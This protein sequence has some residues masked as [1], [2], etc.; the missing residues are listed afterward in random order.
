MADRPSCP[1]PATPARRDGGL[2]PPGRRA[3]RPGVPPGPGDPARPGRGAGR[4]PRRLRPGLAQVGDAARPLA[5]RALVRPDPRQHLPQPAARRAAAGDG[6]LRRGR[7][8]DRRPRRP[9]RGPRGRRRSHRRPV[10]GPPGRRGAALLPRPDRRGHRGAARHP[11]GDGPVA[12]S[13]TRSSGCTRRST[14]PTA[15]GPTDDRP[16]AGAAPAGVVRRCHRRGRDGAGR[17]AQ[18]V[19]AIPRGTGPAAPARRAAEAHAPRR[20]G[21]LLVGGALAAG[22]GHARLA[23]VGAAEPARGRAG[24]GRAP[25]TPPVTPS[26][27]P[28]I[29]AATSSRSSRR[30]KQTKC[31]L[32]RTSCPT[33]RSGSSRQWRRRARGVSGRHRLTGVVAWTPD[34]SGAAVLGR[35]G[36]T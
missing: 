23:T 7:A 20:R 10:A 15:R 6:H 22:S 1:W 26:A 2:H 21:N 11:G 33:P 5:V 4:R 29:G 16:R 25:G 8:R 34:G 31:V 9:D 19:A 30:R 13:T 3:P 32:N 12:A 14:R 27:T 35:R 18:R 36:C 17:A 28:A 24:L